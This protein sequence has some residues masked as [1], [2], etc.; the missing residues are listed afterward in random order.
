MANTFYM[1]DTIIKNMRKL[2]F[3]FCFQCF[4]SL[5]NAQEITNLIFVSSKGVT[6]N[7]KEA[8]SFIL[9]K[10]YPSGSFERKDYKLYGPLKQMKTYSDSSLSILNG[11]YCTY[12][13]NGYIQV[14]GHYLNNK[15]DGYWLKFDEKGKTLVTEK[16][17]SD[18]LVESKIPD[19]TDETKIVPLK[20]SRCRK[21]LSCLSGKTFCRNESRL[22]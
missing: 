4:V 17:L 6:D 11:I 13:V 3:L 15:K 18:S 2:I 19:T 20:Q 21:V 7:V 14:L 16:Y 5:S 12:A 1:T 9:I 8:E 22:L 10:K